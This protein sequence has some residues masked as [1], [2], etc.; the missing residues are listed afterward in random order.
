M[1]DILRE[2]SVKLFPSPKLRLACTL[3][4]EYGD[5]VIALWETDGVVFAGTRAGRLFYL[6]Q[7]GDNRTIEA[8]EV[9][10]P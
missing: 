6:K 2:A 3:P 1:V 5:E 4:L 9:T 10:R 8:C 7:V